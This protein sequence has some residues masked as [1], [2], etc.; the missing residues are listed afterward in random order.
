M[1]NDS[2]IW[3]LGLTW[4]NVAFDASAWCC[5]SLGVLYKIFV[6]FCFWF[7][8]LI[9]WWIA[10]MHE[11]ISGPSATSFSLLLFHFQLVGVLFQFP[12]I[13]IETTL[14]FCGYAG[15]ALYLMDYGVLW[16][17]TFW[18]VAVSLYGGPCVMCSISCMTSCAQCWVCVC[19]Q[20][21]YYQLD[22]LLSVDCVKSV[23]YQESVLFK[24]VL[25]LFLLTF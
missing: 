12:S 1:V 17:M 19:F 15:K 13:S 14:E 2:V 16:L 10:L 3:W 24:Q 5:G 7:C 22:M 18:L 21:L 4:L 11:L 23:M 8:F 9:I 20:L 25:D 6:M